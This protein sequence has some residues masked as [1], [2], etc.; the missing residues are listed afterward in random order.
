MNTWILVTDASRARLF[1][2][3][4]REV[5]WSLLEEFAHPEGRELSREIRPSSP[6]GRMQ[7]NKSPGGR[8]TS[9]EPRTTPKEAETE[10]FA[11][12]LADRLDEATREHKLD[13]L[14]LVASPH[15]LGILKG[16][17]DRQTAKHLRVADDMGLNL[18]CYGDTQSVTP[19]LD[20]LAKEGTRF[21]QAFCTTSSCSPSRSVILTGLYN[22][23][24]GQYGLQHDVHDQHT[25]AWVKSLPALLSAAG[26]RTCSIGKF[27]VGPPEVYPFD[28]FANDGIQG[29]RNEVRMANNAK[30]WIEQ[31]D[32]RPFFLYFCSSDPH[33]AAKGFAN[34]VQR[35]GMKPVKFDPAK[36]KPPA[37][38]PDAPEVRE[39][40][41]EFL[42]ASNRV[43]QGVG[44]LM[45][46]LRETGHDSDTLVIFISDNGPPFP[47]SK[48]GLYEPGANLP[49]LI[50]QK[51]TE[52]VNNALVT[53]A[54]ITPTI[55]D[56]TGAKVPSYA[57]HG[58]SVLPVLE[59]EKVTGWDEVYL[60]HTFHE[61]TMYY[62]MRA[63]RTRKYKY[64]LN[65]ASE[66]PYPFAS[67]LYDSATWQGVLKRG[68][69]QFGPRSVDSLLHRARHELYDLESDPNETVNLA[70]RPGQAAVL[71][72]LKKKLRAWQEQTKDPWVVKYTHE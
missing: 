20:R 49:L 46:V 39:E 22:H 48:T 17:L 38:L 31:K 3:G 70:D 44:R 34:D 26:Y 1:E 11:Q 65:L 18:G 19:N 27:H 60:S 52:V 35:P 12:H 45:E 47:G 16:K 41:A 9:V 56:Y 8:R 53:W 69:S 21:T 51:K 25:H 59:Q 63:I 2:A 62:P 24:N 10:R 33:R 15:F 54:D 23:A 61:I 5:G 29:A 6:P 50:K 71:A 14:V 64:I 42:E 57:L 4:L 36:I 55:L 72:E 37:F 43:D 40:W 13:N 28:K 66:L 32:E 30:Q 58:R 67:D 68:D 7:Q